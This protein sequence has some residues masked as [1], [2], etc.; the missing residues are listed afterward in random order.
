MHGQIARAGYYRTIAS[1]EDACC[2]FTG[3]RGD[4][5][6]LF[7]AVSYLGGCI[8][9]HG[10]KT[11]VLMDDGTANW[12]DSAEGSDRLVPVSEHV[13]DL[14][15]HLLVGTPD[16]DLLLVPPHAR[17]DRCVFTTTLNAPGF[18]GTRSDSMADAADPTGPSR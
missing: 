8:D 7:A 17:G 12:F 14:E 13:C 9:S 4:R 3:I 10:L 18:T 6:G 15:T 5:V 2:S 16:H 11:L 1:V